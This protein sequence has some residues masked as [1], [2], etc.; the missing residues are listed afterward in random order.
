VYDLRLWDLYRG[1]GKSED[2]I[3]WRDAWIQEA[4]DR[5]AVLPPESPDRAQAIYQMGVRLLDRQEFIEAEVSFREC[6]SIRERVR[7]GTWLPHFDRCCLGAALLGQK[8]YAAAEPLLLS[9]YQGMTEYERSIPAD[10]KYQVRRC[11]D[12]LVALYD[13]WDKPTDAA[14]WRAALEATPAPL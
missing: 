11:L 4:R 2:A 8:R 7:A 13:A 1:W 6:L 14:K 9:G 12:W 5:I 3:H 10:Q